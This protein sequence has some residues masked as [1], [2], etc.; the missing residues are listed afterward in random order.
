MYDYSVQYASLSHKFTEK[1]GTDGTFPD[2]YASGGTTWIHDTMGRIWSERR[3][4]GKARGQ[5]GR[6]PIFTRR[7]APRLVARISRAN[8]SRGAPGLAVFETW[9]FP[10]PSAT[11]GFARVNVERSQIS[12]LTTSTTAMPPSGNAPLLETRE[13]RG[14]PS[15]GVVPEIY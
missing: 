7:A 10:E 11:L 3:S 1:L 13:K 8:K 14:T 9:A 15:F 4:I 2:F 6:S 12:I 5:T